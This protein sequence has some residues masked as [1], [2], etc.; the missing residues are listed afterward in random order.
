[1]FNIS[2]Y[3]NISSAKLRLY[4]TSVGTENANTATVQLYGPAPDTWTESGITWDTKPAATS[5][6]ASVDAT[7]ATGT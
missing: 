1:M 2:G 5:L 7:N 4:I 3:S 6:I